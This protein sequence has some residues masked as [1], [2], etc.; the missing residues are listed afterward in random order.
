MI[1]NIS[2]EIGSSTCSLTSLSR[3]RLLGSRR[4]WVRVDVSVIILLMLM[5]V[6][7]R[8]SSSAIFCNAADLG[9]E[10]AGQ[11][12]TRCSMSSTGSSPEMLEVPQQI[13]Q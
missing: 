4:N 8:G 2:R 13:R 1:L 6:L 9:A 5:G 12:E 11:T 7:E 10:Y 3:F